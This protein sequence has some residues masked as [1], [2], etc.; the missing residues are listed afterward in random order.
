MSVA[1]LFAIWIAWIVGGT[2]LRSPAPAHH[3]PGNA[4]MVLAEGRLLSRT[5][6]PGEA[7]RVLLASFVARLPD[8]AR[9]KPEAWLAARPGVA[10]EDI[11]R[12]GRYRRRLAEG[13]SVPLD[14]FHDLLTRLR[15]AIA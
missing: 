12:L 4:A 8:A 2:R 1:A 7:A 15:S 3:P 6:D 5:V 13:G 14:P 10:A 11:E 9:E